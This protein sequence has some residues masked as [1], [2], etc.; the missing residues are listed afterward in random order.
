MKREEIRKLLESRD[1]LAENE[2][3]D[4]LKYYSMPVPKYRVIRTQRDVGE[5]DMKFPVALKVC[6]PKILHKTDVGGVILN[7]ENKDQ[8]S[9]EIENMKTR[10]PEENLLL[11]EMMP[12]GTELIMGLIRDPT[13]GLSIMVGIGGI[14]TEVYKDVTFRV[15]PIERRDAEQMLSELKGRVLLEGFRGIKRDRE[16][17]IQLM[18]DLSEF[19]TSLDEYIDQMDLN[20][21]FVYEKGVIIVDAKLMLKKKQKVEA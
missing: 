15:L 1:S 2:V 21:I 17:V 11:E 4:L 7:I 9:N 13:F 6:S 12:L 19:G 16:A 5:I 8:L 10:F 3:K 18:L 20:P 14:F